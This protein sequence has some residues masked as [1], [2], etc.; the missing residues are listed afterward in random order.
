MHGGQRFETLRFVW[1]RPVDT[2]RLSV[3]QLINVCVKQFVVSTVVEKVG[4]EFVQ[5]PQCHQF[6]RTSPG[7][8]SI[9]TEGVVCIH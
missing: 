8:S 6:I 5:L 4:N 7:S 2:L 1:T 9:A 3:E